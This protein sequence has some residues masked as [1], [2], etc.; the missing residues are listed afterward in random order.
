MT[1]DTNVW[2]YIKTGC[3]DALTGPERLTMEKLAVVIDI[4]DRFYTFGSASVTA[5]KAA[6]SICNYIQGFSSRPNVR[7]VVV[8]VDLLFWTPYRSLVAYKRDASRNVMDVEVDVDQPLN[9]E[10]QIN[11]FL[12]HYVNKKWRATKWYPYLGD[13]LRR[14]LPM[15][16]DQTI[17][18]DGFPFQQAHVRIRYA[19]YVQAHRSPLPYWPQDRVHSPYDAGTMVSPVRI[20][21]KRHLSQVVVPV[22]SQCI[23]GDNRILW[24]GIAIVRHA[25]IYSSSDV[26]LVSCDGDIFIGLLI[27]YA[28]LSIP[29]RPEPILFGKMLKNELTVVSIPTIAKFIHRQFPE[30]VKENR[31]ASVN[32][33]DVCI[34]KR[35]V[36]F[37]CI[38]SLRNDYVPSY[39][40][41]SFDKLWEGYVKYVNNPPSALAYASFSS[42]KLIQHQRT[43]LLTM[44]QKDGHRWHQVNFRYIAELFNHLIGASALV[45]ESIVDNVARKATWY[46]NYM[47]RET[48]G[49]TPPDLYENEGRTYGIVYDGQYIRDRLE[50]QS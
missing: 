2:K 47:Y 45:K 21:Q 50:M 13:Y 39:P 9:D 8:V 46:L 31:D 12:A 14:H 1:L 34:E 43:H 24:W 6:E 32:H 7:Y 49:H 44:V 3:K 29:T 17:I 30:A 5:A 23:E 40:R 33:A 37:A 4:M 41:I 18:L 36:E 11:D 19:E 38:A 20:T 10:T 42:D 35:C 28:H 16:E 22:G 48:F 27:A 25:N 26:L 15:R